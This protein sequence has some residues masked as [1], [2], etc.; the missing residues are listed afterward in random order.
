MVTNCWLEEQ[1]GFRPK[2]S[3]EEHIFTLS[4]ILKTRT[5]LKL[6]TFVAFID[7]EKAFDKIDRQLLLY[8]LYEPGI[9]G[10][11]IELLKLCIR[12]IQVL[13]A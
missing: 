7:F 6:D 4:S 1:N 10:T 5:S 9:K 3:C 11:C 12:I 2:R 8:K 13:F